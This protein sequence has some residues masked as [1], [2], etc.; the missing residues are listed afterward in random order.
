MGDT[1]S[2]NRIPQT[3]ILDST[4]ATAISASGRDF[5][6]ATIATTNNTDSEFREVMHVGVALK[7]SGDSGSAGLNRVSISFA[8][9]NPLSAAAKIESAIEEQLGGEYR[10]GGAL[11]IDVKAMADIYKMRNID[12]T[13]L[14][15]TSHMQTAAKGEITQD[16]WDT[17]TNLIS[18][19]SFATFA[20]TS[21]DWNGVK[22]VKATEV[23]FQ[24]S[25]TSTAGVSLTPELRIMSDELA[26]YTDTTYPDR[27][28]QFAKHCYG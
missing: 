7:A 8:D 15:G 27:L 5:D 13:S 14:A 19:G 25:T 24:F 28:F 2:I 20:S 23:Y 1:F 9:S 4:G 16:L 12:E 11:H 17:T 26:G 18:T 21:A 10:D 3:L 6:P 22:F